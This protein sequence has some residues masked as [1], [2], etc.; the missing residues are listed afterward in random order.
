MS[1]K[2]EERGLRKFQILLIVK[3]HLIKA[4]GRTCIVGFQTMENVGFKDLVYFP[5]S[6]FLSN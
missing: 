5:V 1:E 6:H 4:K 2:V 3:F